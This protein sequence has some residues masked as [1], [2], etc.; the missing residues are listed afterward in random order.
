M[1]DSLRFNKV[2]TYFDKTCGEVAV[3]ALPGAG[4]PNF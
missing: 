3:V 4:R 1:Q 2:L